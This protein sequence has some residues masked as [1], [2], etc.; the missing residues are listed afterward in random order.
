MRIPLTLLFSI[1]VGF[2][3]G[4]KSVIGLPPKMG[5]SLKDKTISAQKLA[6]NR[7]S[8]KEFPKEKRVEVWVG[9]KFF[10]AYTW[11]SPLKK[12]VLWPIA[13]STGQEITRGFPLKLK[14]DDHTD[15]PHHVGL[16]L[17]HGNVN[18]HD[19]WN[20]SDNIGPEHAGPFGTILHQGYKVISEGVL[21]VLACSS[22]WVDSKGDTVLAEN[23]L[24]RFRSKDSIRTIERIT[25]LKA[26][27]ADVSFKDNKEGFLG[28]RVRTALEKSTDANNSGTYVSSKGLSG[29]SVWGKRAEFVALEG[30]ISGKPIQVII[31]DHPNNPNYPAH[32]HARGY[33]LF[34]IN[35]LGS[36]VFT[37]GKESLDFVLPAGKD[38]LF[39]YRVEIRAGKPA[40]IELLRKSAEEF[41]AR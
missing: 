27:K 9:N 33:G 41:G 2:A 8:F 18:G 4:Q 20:N 14:G 35:N 28:L 26:L 19:Y 21:G 39:A 38:Q 24:F 37:K 6:E 23:T 3:F 10:T 22:F 31:Y 40:T 32:W 16:W 25:S 34:G 15:H 7:V 11:V 12:P 13:A 1:W 5:N 36:R 17:N 30:K 29:D